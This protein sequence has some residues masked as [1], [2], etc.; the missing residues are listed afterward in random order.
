MSP[1]DRLLLALL[2]LLRLGLDALRLLADPRRYWNFEEAYNAS[3]GWALTRTGLL[4]EALTL[5][6]R[7]FCGGCTAVA[8]LGAPL[9]ALGDRFLLWK[10]L[11]LLWT[12]ATMVAGFKAMD[13]S[14][15]RGA[16]WAFALLMAVP[17]LGPADL[18]LMLWGN[19]QETALFVALGLWALAARRPLA[20][21]LAMGLGVWFCRTALYP[22]VVLIPAGLLGLPRARVLGGLLLG[23]S[24]LLLPAAGG[25][26]GFYRMEA[27]LGQPWGEVVERLTTLLDPRALG[28]RLYLSLGGMG[29]AAGLWLGAALGAG[30]MTLAARRGRL[31]LL[32]PLSYAAFY[33]ISRF[34]LFLIHPRAQLN[35]NRYLSPWAWALTLLV[36]AGVGLLW[37]RGRRRLALALLAGPLLA[38]G[39]GLARALRWPGDLRALELKASHE[40]YFAEV[41]SERL[42]VDTL[43]ALEP[44]DPRARALVARVAGMRLGG[45][46]RAG[47]R[48]ADESIAEARGI[49]LEALAGLGVRA[50]EPCADPSVAKAL[51]AGLEE[52][53]RSAL[54]RGLSV[55]LSACERRDGLQ[56]R[57]ESL[58]EP[59]GCPLCPAAG[60]LLFLACAEPSGDLVLQGRCVARRASAFPEREALLY[61]AGLWFWRPTR[62]SAELAAIT[63]GLGEGAEPFLEGYADPLA[64]GVGAGR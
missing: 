57:V 55:A 50:V 5:Q 45:A 56:A 27:A 15:G 41:L 54:A 46:L 51:L 48:S 25:D 37:A 4:G 7:E 40:A 36:A 34:P 64:G 49:G 21:G 17:A 39:V 52:P 58:R 60:R 19:H 24:P 38:N 13:L 11:A 18:S 32:L 2:V 3:V 20:L 44:S 47:R 43:A 26:A 59:E 63:A 9:L 22:A 1:R 8:A 62:P 30:A 12:A 14:V 31:L 42:P 6:Y 28:E 16:A 61:G 23:L 33:A 35:N 10:G 53:E 29:W